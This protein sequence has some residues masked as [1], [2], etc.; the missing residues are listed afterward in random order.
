[1]FC[2]ECGNQIGEEE[3]CPVC[4]PPAAAPVPADGLSAPELVSETVNAPP[5]VT[6][7]A[8]SEPEP[9][10]EFETSGNP[11]NHGLSREPRPLEVTAPE[12]PAPPSDDR[13]SDPATVP[14]YL[15]PPTSDRAAM[16]EAPAQPSERTEPPVFSAAAVIAE[17]NEP[18]RTTS[19][20]TSALFGGQLEADSSPQ[21]AAKVKEV[22][23]DAT[24]AFTTV[25]VNPVGGLPVAF[26]KLGQARALAAGVVFAVVSLLL[27]FIGVYAGTE[28]YSRPD[29]VDS[30]KFLMF[31]TFPFLIVLGASAATRKLLG[32]HG[33]IH[34]DAFIAGATVLP[35]G[36][37][38]LVI[39]VLGLAGIDAVAILTLIA[40]SFTIL[41][42]YTGIT[43]ISQLAESRAA[44]AIPI[45]IVIAFVVTK[46]IFN[47]VLPA[48]VPS[49]GKVFG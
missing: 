34:G 27:T 23:L 43:R 9:H 41:I 47:A 39:G 15:P 33:S 17:P 11:E 7:I 22:G 28:S 31:G 8:V 26:E 36:F 44:F 49:P 4:H 46:V 1:M 30:I 24:Q 10:P 29:I 37:L 32:G 21:V 14:E 45:I 13:I 5:P 2:T 12:S 19:P 3:I 38:I 48:L 16:V 18:T 20:A 25:A 40:L 42:L 6:R 35:L